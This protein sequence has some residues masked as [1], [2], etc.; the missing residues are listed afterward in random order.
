MYVD[1]DVYCFIHL[2][3]VFS[4]VACCTIVLISNCFHIFSYKDST[5]L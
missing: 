5:E 1:V 2:E 3:N 4:K